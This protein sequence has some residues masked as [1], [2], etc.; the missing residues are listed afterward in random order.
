[1]TK[2]AIDLYPYIMYPDIKTRHRKT[3]TWTQTN[4]TQTWISRKNLMADSE[5][6]F[7][8]SIG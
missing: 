8:P 3:K 1:M 2:A 6:R 5:E 7:T 4:I